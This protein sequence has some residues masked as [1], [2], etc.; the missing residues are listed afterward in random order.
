M[1][2][3]YIGLGLFCLAA[4][5]DDALTVDVEWLVKPPCA[6]TQCPG[7]RSIKASVDGSE[8]YAVSCELQGSEESRSLLFRAQKLDGLN[9]E[10]GIELRHGLVVNN[11]FV[12]GDNCRF[13]AIEGNTYE[14]AC[15]IGSP[16]ASQPCQISDFVLEEGSLSMMILCQLLPL[17]IYPE[18]T[19]TVSAPDGISQPFEVKCTNL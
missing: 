1:M 2:R 11:Q 19:A 8:G 16:S 17:E 3:N 6:S 9:V 12:G 14:G 5:G 4:C 7:P 13:E 18:Q 10:Y 15:G